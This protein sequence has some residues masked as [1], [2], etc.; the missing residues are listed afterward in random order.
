MKNLGLLNLSIGGVVLRFYLMMALVLAVAFTG[1][2]TIA[3]IVAVVFA[4]GCILAIS[5]KSG[6]KAK[7]NTRVITTSK[8]EDITAAA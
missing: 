3:A 8:Q 1:Q 7:E 2:F 4:A 6:N 5:F